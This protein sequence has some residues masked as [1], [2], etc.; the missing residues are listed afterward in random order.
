[1]HEYM[2]ILQFITNISMP[3]TYIHTVT[4]LSTVTNI[5]TVT[6]LL[7]YPPTYCTQEGNEAMERCLEVI[8][9]SQ[10]QCPQLLKTFALDAIHNILSVRPG[11]AEYLSTA[12]VQEQG[13]LR[14]A[15]VE[16]FYEARFA[17][18]IK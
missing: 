13:E 8:E 17:H 12:L 18:F 5:L 7:P 11:R 1:M 6:S 15:A 3:S 10:R 2:L 4:Y 14:Q 9:D 16:K